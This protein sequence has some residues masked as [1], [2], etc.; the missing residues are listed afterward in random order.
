M[1][2]QLPVTRI[3]LEPV[4]LRSKSIMTAAFLVLF[5]HDGLPLPR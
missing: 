5:V 2:S 3:R 1:A 4:A